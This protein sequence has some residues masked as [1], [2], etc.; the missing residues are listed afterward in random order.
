MSG[1]PAAAA[2]DGR[3]VVSGLGKTFGDVR[4][5]ED[6]S[7]SVEAGSITGF[8]G[9]NGAGK[10]T[11]L[12]MLL[13]LVRPTSGTA[14]IG[15]RPYAE[16]AQPA[17]VV[18]AALEATSFYP[19]RSARNHLRVLCAA[20]G[21]PLQRADE[22]LVQV[23]LTDA[24]FRRVGGF[25]LGMRQRLALAG[26]LLGDPAVL[27]LDEPANGLDPEGIA[28]LRGFL[29]HLADSGRT[30]L[31]S[32]HVLAEVAQTVDR[33]VIIAR[34]RLVR[35]A[36]LAE[37]TAGTGGTRVRSPEQDRLAEALR[38]EGRSVTTTPD[39]ALFVPGADTHDVGRLAWQERVELHELSAPPA[40]LESVFLALTSA[41]GAS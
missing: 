14:T 34:G 21:L 15:G 9:P 3:I 19:G 36:A 16:L 4:A 38:R 8:L 26:A 20:N 11:T 41:Q 30:I 32:S 37:L 31:V 1:L 35:E 7:F 12:R 10:T 18:G 2:T 29:R 22:C 6:L 25:S 28:W 5:V 23:G 17:R 33:V 13:G 40:E 24:A 39:G 27:L